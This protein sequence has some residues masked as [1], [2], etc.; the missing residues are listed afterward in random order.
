MSL[1]D[2]RR[3]IDDAY[4]ELVKKRQI[5]TDAQKQYNQLIAGYFHNIN[6]E[7]IYE[8]YSGD[9]CIDRFKDGNSAI[10]YI[11]GLILD[12]G[13]TSLTIKKS[14]VWRKATISK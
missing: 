7:Y 9:R 5:H 13:D 6:V 2:M 1:E 8:I 3:N 4:A 11:R 10:E 14:K 12:S